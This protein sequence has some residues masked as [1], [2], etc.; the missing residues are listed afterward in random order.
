MEDGDDDGLGGALELAYC[1]L[2]RRDRSEAEV[3]RHLARRGL[4]RALVD[5]AVARLREQGYLDD[6]R[7]ARRFAAD[8]RTL[9][10]WGA[11]RIEAALRAAGVPP[12][13]VAAACGERGDEE[14]LAAAVALLRRRVTLP[15]G[16]DRERQRALALLVRRGYELEIAYAAVRQFSAATPL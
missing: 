12:E 11:G 3:R 14:E 10:G 5:T 9:D 2:G 8:R 1:Q 13:H 15:P 4:D 6:G 16:D 7:F